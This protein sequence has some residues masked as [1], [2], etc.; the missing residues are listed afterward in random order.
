MHWHALIATE[1]EVWLDELVATNTAPQPL[2]SGDSP[3]VMWL[4]SAIAGRL[5]RPSLAFSPHAPWWSMS[6]L[7][8]H[9]LYQSLINN[10]SGWLDTPFSQN[11][12]MCRR[13]S[14]DGVELGCMHHLL[15]GPNM[16]RGGK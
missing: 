7:H 1:V 15:K 8:L 3:E 12:H 2:V 6:F 10:T 14:V 11:I 5:S 16:A 9:G 4:W 13:S